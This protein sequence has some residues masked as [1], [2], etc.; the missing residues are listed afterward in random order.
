M[1]DMK[2]TGRKMT[3]S[4]RVV[5]MTAS[6]ISAVASLAACRVLIFF[7]STKR[8]MFSRTTIASS[9]TMPTISTR[10]SIVTLLS[11]KWSARIMPNVAMIDA[12]IATPAIIVE[13]QERM[14]NKTT[15]HARILPAM[16][17]IW[18]S[19]SAASM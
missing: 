18:I 1:E 19:P 2:E 10:A 9:I 11:V 3:T 15:K 7:S 16:R 5:A 8:K 12:G 4:D 17:W 13:R 14:N 6:P